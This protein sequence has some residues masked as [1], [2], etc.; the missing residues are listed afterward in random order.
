MADDTADTRAQVSYL[1]PETL[2]HNP[3]FSQL[4]V[5]SGNART[6]YVGG[7][8][9]VDATGAVVG[10]GDLAAQVKQVLHNLKAALAAGGATL[11]HVVKWNIYIVQGQSLEVGFAAFQQSAGRLEHPPAITGLFVAALANPAYLVEIDAVAVVP[12]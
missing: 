9:A 11:E 10:Q 5:V 8:D 3:A 6:I 2:S 1:S 7:Q 4:V 12:E